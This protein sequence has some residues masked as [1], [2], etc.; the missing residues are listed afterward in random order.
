MQKKLRYSRNSVYGFIQD[1]SAAKGKAV[2]QMDSLFT[3]YQETGIN[4]LFCYNSAPGGKQL[5][6]GLPRTAH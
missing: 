5:Y 6:M 3:L 4:N 1:Y 2:R